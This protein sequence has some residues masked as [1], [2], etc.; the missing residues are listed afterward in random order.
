MCDLGAWEGGDRQISALTSRTAEP[1]CR[2][3]GSCEKTFPKN[4]PNL[5]ITPEVNVWAPCVCACVRAH[6]QYIHTNA[7]QKINND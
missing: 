2:A 6:T 7:H 4:I 3:L 1:K 5:G